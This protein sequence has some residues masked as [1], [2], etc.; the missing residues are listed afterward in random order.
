MVFVAVWVFDENVAAAFFTGELQR[1]HDGF[2]LGI[3]AGAGLRTD[4]GE[5]LPP[6]IGVLSDSPE[7]HGLSPD[8]Y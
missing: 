8:M 7:R 6:L 3:D 5:H 4:R 2:V 1:G